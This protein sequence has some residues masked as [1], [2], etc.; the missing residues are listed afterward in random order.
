[1]KPLTTLLCLACALL[2]LAPVHALEDTA[3]RCLYVEMAK[4]PIRYVGQGLAPA[5]DGTIDGMPATMLVD[6]GAFDTQLTMN[7]ANKRDLTLHMT[8][9]LAQGV[10]GWSRLYAARVR[11]VTL[12]PTRTRRS[13]YLSVIGDA[14]L[15]P[16]FDAIIGAPFLLQADLE[17]DLTAKQ[18]RLFR[19]Q[20]CG[21]TDL[22]IWKEDTIVIPFESS[23]DRSP[24]PHFTVKV[25]GVKL[26]A[27]IDTGAHH[28]L[29]TTDAARRIG[30]D[31][32]GPDVKRSGYIVGVGSER[33]AQWT[34]TFKSVEIGNETI[35]DAELGILESQGELSTDL[36]VGQ[37][38]LRAHRVLFAMSQKK[39]Y[40][41]YTGGTPFSRST[42]L[43]PWMRAE[44]EAG[45]PDAQFTVAMMY[46][47]GRGVARDTAQA[48]AW[49][50]KAAAG[51]EPHA[52]LM[53]GRRRLQAGQ[54]SEAI[55]KLRAGLALL[56]AERYGPL[57]LYT[58]RVR[59]GE[60]A[61]AKSELEASV[62]KQEDDW[63]RP[64]A[65]F[66]L[67]KL[68]AAGLLDAAGKDAKL[69][70]G[71][72]CQANGYMAEWHRARGD[73]AQAESL[74]ATVRAHCGAA[75]APA[76]PA[77]APVPVPDTGAAS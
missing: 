27:I 13:V 37:D 38:F 51:G 62:K 77:S 17:V 15:T 28:T 48:D 75:P 25:N 8:G 73:T 7:G 14:N 21:K 4:L 68:D 29:M 34:A 43:E 33:A 1:M 60:P 32:K 30:I 2:P 19:Q 45:N 10:G 22:A 46:G 24:N 18:V 12:G 6:T 49:L 59:N 55:P 74:M 26:D 65:E 64:I 47:S 40:I 9:R 58:A 54:A 53:L 76:T 5:V 39:L 23:R 69:A 44:A 31:L 36:L 20:D 71:R 72:S 3:P 56:P 52:N 35:R 66:Y 63:P 57:W 16:A 61:L 70:K 41:A 42:G 11:E 50:D 67:G